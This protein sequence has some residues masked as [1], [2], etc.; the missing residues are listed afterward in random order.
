MC[1]Q[2]HG[3]TT[4]LAPIERAHMTVNATPNNPLIPAGLSK[5]A[6]EIRSVT[7][8]TNGHPTVTFRITKDT[9]TGGTKDTGPSG[10][11]PTSGKT[12]D[13][14]PQCGCAASETRSW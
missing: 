4:G 3:A 13:T 11:T 10:C 6:Y 14:F 9:G 12:C 1:K 5:F 8:S 2:C 7:T